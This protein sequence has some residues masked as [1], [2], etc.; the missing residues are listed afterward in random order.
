MNVHAGGEA[1]D[2]A[3]SREYLLSREH[4][5]IR[6]TYHYYDSSEGEQRKRDLANPGVRL[7]AEGRWS[8]LEQALSAHRLPAGVSILDVGC[9]GGDDL[10]RIADQ[11]ALLYP[12]LHGID[13][14]PNRIARASQAV[15][16]AKFSVGGAECLPYEDQ[17]F[18]VVIAATVFSSI[19]DQSLSCAVAKEISRVLSA[20]GIVICY[21]MRYPNPWNSHTRSIGRSEIME[22]FPGAE[23]QLSSV[24]LLP[25]LARRLGV[26]T[27][28]LYGPLHAL[29]WLRSHYVAVISTARNR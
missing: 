27:E 9:G 1:I 15:P 19:L 16:G 11:F 22:M 26:A 3:E 4:E 20:T 25:P 24:T 8:A 17:R 18:D 7:N 2:S 29:P 23:I 21:D 13:L 28:L 6:A 10:R 5:R 14:L 12:S